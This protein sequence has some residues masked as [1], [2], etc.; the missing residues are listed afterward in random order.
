MMD[1]HWIAVLAAGIISMVVGSIW[2]S[3]VMFAKPWMESLG[4]SDKKLSEMKKNTSMGKTYS[5]MFLGAL[6]MGYVMAMLVRVTN[7]TMLDTGGMLG[8][9]VWLGFVAPAMLGGVLFEQKPMQ[10]YLVNVGYYLVVLV[11]IGA[12][13]AVWR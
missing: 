1:V 10:W 13:L 11:L 3:P 9:W 8:F 5:I 6:V 12:L 7:T 4:L 2:Y